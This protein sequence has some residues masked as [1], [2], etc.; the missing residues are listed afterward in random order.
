MDLAAA[1]LAAG[2]SAVRAPASA[3]VGRDEP[4]F[5]RV[6]DDASLAAIVEREWRAAGDRTVAVITPR[7]G[8]AVGRRPGA[9]RAA[10]G[11]RHR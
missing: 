9:R 10:G 4:E 3:R 6:S 2:G 8:H 11:R 7:A 1:V 5:T